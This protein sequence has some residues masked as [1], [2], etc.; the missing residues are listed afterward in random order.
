MTTDL[1]NILQNQKIFRTLGPTTLGELV[2]ETSLCSLTADQVLF[3]QGDVA[4]AMFVVLEGRLAVTVLHNAA[5]FLVGRI[6]PGDPVG[7]MQVLAGGNRTATVTAVTNCRLLRLP[8]AVLRELSRRFPEMGTLLDKTILERLRS[9][10]L[11]FTLHGL[12]GELNPE[13][14]RDFL[15]HGRWLK[16]SKGEV[17]FRQG[18]QDD[19]FYLVVSGRFWVSCSE[20]NGGVRSVAEVGRGETIGEMS[21]LSSEPRSA[22]VTAI[23]DSEVVRFSAEDFTALLNRYPHGFFKLTSRIVDR[24]RHTLRPPSSPRSA[25]N[26]VLVPTDPAAPVQDLTD[27]LTAAL[28]KHGPSLALNAETLDRM[29]QYPASGTRPQDP[30]DLALSAWLDGQERMYRFILYQIEYENTPWRR[31]CL[32]RADCILVVAH[33]PPGPEITDLLPWGIEES[34]GSTAQRVLVCLSEDKGIAPIPTRPWLQNLPLKRH[35]HLREG[36]RSDLGRLARLLAGKAIG[37]VLGGGGARALAQIGVIEAMEGA[38][39]P[40]DM[41]GG[42]SMGAVVGAMYCMGWT[43]QEMIEACREAFAKKNPLSDYTLP[44]RALVKGRV[45]EDYLQGAFGETHI[46]DLD[47]EFFCVSSN[48]NTA[49]LVVHSRGLL[50]QALRAS[51][52]LPGVLPPV[53]LDGMLLVDGS[54]LNN[55]PVDVMKTK[56]GGFILAVDVSQPDQTSPDCCQTGEQNPSPVSLKRRKGATPGII[57]VITRSLCLGGARSV[58]ENRHLADVYIKPPL[59]KFG[60]VEFDALDELVTLGREHAKSLLNRIAGLPDS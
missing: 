26:I 47:K 59:G 9:N 51:L 2:C 16:I 20:E 45:L 5:A 38:G 8:N 40:I 53:A 33:Q 57:D 4:D 32:E 11:A 3:S 21:M 60:F 58:Q 39:L 18:Q 37:L 12:F 43:T 23:R 34:S 41:V 13:Q 46:E 30:F 1:L 19:N 42:C 48:L 24:L 14:L 22:N 17:L 55:L 44:R 15:T 25:T 29:L 31:R 54:M 10:Q 50:R 27:R 35:I 49:G 28:R 36:V 52:S 6:G 56:G 7:E